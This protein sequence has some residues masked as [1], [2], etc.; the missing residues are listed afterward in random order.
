ML[1]PTCLLLLPDDKLHHSRDLLQLK[2]LKL[3]NRLLKPAL[4]SL[5]VR[6]PL[7]LNLL[8][9]VADLG[10][11]VWVIKDL[12]LLVDTLLRLLELLVRLRDLVVD[13]DAAGDA[14]V[15][16]GCCG[17]GEGDAAGRAGVGGTEDLDGGYTLAAEGLDGLGLGGDGGF[18]G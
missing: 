1:S 3:L 4:L 15:H 17:D 18:G 5:Q 6:Q 14:E 10:L 13:V 7:A 11:V 12:A 16:D 9:R 2:L 8:E